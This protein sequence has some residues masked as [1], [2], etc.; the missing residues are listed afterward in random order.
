MNCEREIDFSLPGREM[1]SQSLMKLSLSLSRRYSK[2]ARAD[3]L[4]AMLKRLRS[5]RS[6]LCLEARNRMLPMIKAA[7]DRKVI[8]TKAVLDLKVSCALSYMYDMGT[9]QA[10][11]QSFISAL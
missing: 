3:W 8:S 6:F 2:T 5:R 11:Y 7:M 1:C 9:P 10:I 4:T